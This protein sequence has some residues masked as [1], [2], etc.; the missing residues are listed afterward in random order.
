MAYAS[1]LCKKVTQRIACL[2]DRPMCKG[3]DWNAG[4]IFGFPTTQRELVFHDTVP[5]EEEKLPQARKRAARQKNNILTI[6]RQNPLL[7]L[8][9][10]EV[11]T[12]YKELFGTI[13]ITSVRRGMTDLTMK[14]GTGRL[15]KGSVEDQVKGKW[16]VKN[17]RWRYNSDYV[18][19][20]NLQK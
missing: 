1:I 10:H 19:A 5:F 13:L 14:D 20:I 12:L 8:T 6:F 15:R 11:R 9:P 18:P 16:N 7:W 3:C 4:E 17:N 2:G